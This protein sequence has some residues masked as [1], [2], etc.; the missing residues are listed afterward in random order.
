MLVGYVKI[1]RGRSFV[2]GIGSGETVMRKP[3]MA[4]GGGIYFLSSSGTPHSTPWG[5][6]KAR[7]SLI[8][9]CLCDVP[10]RARH[11]AVV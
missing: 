7:D 8:C 10:H 1:W 6:F 5:C 3:L 11:I 9:F 2:Q 4:V